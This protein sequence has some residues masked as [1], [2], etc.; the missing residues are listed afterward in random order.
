M[1]GMMEPNVVVQGTT[2]VQINAGQRVTW[3]TMPSEI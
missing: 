2:L 1:A 3:D